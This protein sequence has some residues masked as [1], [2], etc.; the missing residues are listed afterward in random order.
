MSSAFAAPRGA[1]PQQSALLWLAVRLSLNVRG[2]AATG[3]LW[4]AAATAVAGVPL[5]V[6]LAAAQSGALPGRTA[7]SLALAACPG[8]AGT[9]WAAQAVAADRAAIAEA[10]R[11][12]GAEQAVCWLLPAVRVALAAAFGTLGAAV[13]LVLLRETLFR[14]LSEKSP[15][16][17]AVAATSTGDWAL[18]AIGAAALLTACALF[19]SG[20]GHRLA[21]RQWSRLSARFER[22]ARAGAGARTR[23]A[24][25]KTRGRL[26]PRRAGAPPQ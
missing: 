20:A 17:L 3:L 21:D 25:A 1:G 22:A 14:A 23:A 12:V 4:L 19:A 26:R 6:W 10:L 15:L 24:K 11:Q 8:V 13:G 16:H 9:L 2:A 7:V 18:A 5:T